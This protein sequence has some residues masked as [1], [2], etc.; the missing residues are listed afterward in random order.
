MTSIVEMLQWVTWMV[1][2]IGTYS[3]FHVMQFIGTQLNMDMIVFYLRDGIVWYVSVMGEE[4]F[5]NCKGV[6]VDVF[7]MT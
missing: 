5:M 7:Y 1:L 3:P 2:V 6:F 4:S